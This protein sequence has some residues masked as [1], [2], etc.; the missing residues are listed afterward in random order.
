MNADHIMNMSLRAWVSEYLEDV[1]FSV[2]K[3]NCDGNTLF[4]HTKGVEDFS[5]FF[6]STMRVLKPLLLL[7]SKKFPRVFFERT[8]R[9]S[10]PEFTDQNF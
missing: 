2:S 10:Q 7:K 8:K 1:V 9:V 6:K 3:V 4:V 5:I